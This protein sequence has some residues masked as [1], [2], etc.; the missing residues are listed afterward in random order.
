MSTRDSRAQ[1]HSLYKIFH[2]LFHLFDSLQ[3]RV[4]QL[5]RNRVQQLHYFVAQHLVTLAIVFDILDQASH[6]ESFTSAPEMARTF[7]ISQIS[8]ASSAAP[9]RLPPIAGTISRTGESTLSAC[10][11]WSRTP[12]MPQAFVAW[13]ISTDET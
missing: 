1:N 3:R 4:I 7:T 10:M 9:L 11:D 13:L 8:E 6:V 12:M 5:S 2:L